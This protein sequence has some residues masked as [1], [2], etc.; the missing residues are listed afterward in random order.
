ML[1]ITASHKQV[2]ERPYES[3]QISTM[4]KFQQLYGLFEFQMKLPVTQGAWPATYLLPWD[5]DWPPEIDISELAGDDAGEVL[6]TNHYSDDYGRHLQDNL[7]FSADGLDRTQWHTYSLVW[8]PGSVSWYLDNVFRGSCGLPDSGVSDVPMY[9]N[10]N[11]A[12]GD[13]SGDPSMSTWPQTYCCR[14][15]SIYQRNDLP[16]PVYAENSPEITLSANTAT[17]SAI[18]CNPL[19]PFDRKWV[20]VDG[21]GTAS[22]DHP[23][24]ATTKVTLRVPGMYHFRFTIANGKSSGVDD[25]LVYINNAIKK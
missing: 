1:T 5:N 25:L 10:I 4:G 19:T 12:I 20:L 8:E 7:N 15:V 2:N 24:M 16:L 22:I 11:L 3:G 17:L 18:T 21:P 9:V 13:Y 23:E 14:Q 6:Q